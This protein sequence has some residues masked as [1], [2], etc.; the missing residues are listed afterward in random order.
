MSNT[1]APFFPEL[2]GSLLGQRARMERE[3]YASPPGTWEDFHRR[4]GAWTAIN[5][6]ILQQQDAA[7]AADEQEE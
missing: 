7:K 3:A 6:L 4:L 5:D 2:L 1:P